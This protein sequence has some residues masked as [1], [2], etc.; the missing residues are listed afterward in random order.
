MDPRVAALGHGTIP[1]EKFVAVIVNAPSRRI[2]LRL[3]RAENSAV[4]LQMPPEIE[5]KLWRVSAKLQETHAWRK[6]GT[7][8]YVLLEKPLSMGIGCGAC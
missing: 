2:I 4:R 6:L 8:S 3:E 1:Q 5:P 7:V